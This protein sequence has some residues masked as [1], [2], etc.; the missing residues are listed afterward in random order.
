MKII[1]IFTFL[2]SLFGCLPSN[3][4]TTSTS[5]TIGTQFKSYVDKFI[6]NGKSFNRQL[7]ANH[8][9]IKFNSSLSGTRTLAQCILNP[10]SPSSYQRIEVNP[11]FWENVNID[12]REYVLFHELGHCLLL[13]DHDDAT[14]ETSDGYSI[15]KSIMSTY[16]STSDDY[17]NNYS[18]YLHELFTSNTNDI[19]FFK[20]NGYT[21]G[22][23]P[24]AYYTNTTS[25]SAL[26]ATTIHKTTIS[27]QALTNNM[28]SDLSN[29]SCE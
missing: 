23:F 3:S 19:T 27:N 14:I 21:T 5:S 4:G 10:S 7:S 12:S 22:Q 18:S 25:T 9:T 26:T 16:F 6:S 20:Y 8:L 13:R 28:Y 2:F 11:T 1:I 29:F 24:Y 17:V 15:N